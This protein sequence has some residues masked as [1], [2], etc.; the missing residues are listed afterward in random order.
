M[1]SNSKQEPSFLELHSRSHVLVLDQ[2]KKKTDS[3][4]FFIRCNIST[5]VDASPS[6]T[7]VIFYNIQAVD[8][9]WGILFIGACVQKDYCLCLFRNV[10]P[11]SVGETLK[12]VP[13]FV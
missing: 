8:T 7:D 13:G 10:L 5:G 6:V 2:G 3:V 1:N 11:G 12:T 9:S 4:C